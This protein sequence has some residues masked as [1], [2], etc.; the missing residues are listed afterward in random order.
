VPRLTSDDLDGWVREFHALEQAHP[1]S[2]QAVDASWDESL[3]DTGLVVVR[4]ET[5]GTEAFLRREIGGSPEWTVTFE[6]RERE[7]RA[8]A[9][10]VLALAAEVGSVARLCAF[11]TEKTTEHLDRL[12]R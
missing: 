8:T 3:V 2:T 4:L 7:A 11:L 6:A 9:Q 1:S 10:Q 5:S 12:A